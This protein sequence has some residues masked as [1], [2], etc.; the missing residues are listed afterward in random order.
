MTQDAANPKDD[1]KAAKQRLRLWLRLLGCSGRL[2]RELRTRLRRRF[3]TTLPRFD[4]L[5]TLAR[6]PE[7]MTMGDLSRRLM[8]SAGNTTTVVERLVR[9]G[10]LR[11]WSPPDD[12]RTTYVGL[13]AAG[14]QAFA[15]LARAHERW[16]A[17]L[18]ADL[19]ED[20]VQSLLGLLL[21]TR[22]AI[23]AGIRRGTKQ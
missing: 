15:L 16:I 4:V 10:Q 12:R 7:G 18:I 3:G 23:E 5:A 11:R 6:T 17:E 22:T 8:V 20:D 19:R 14:E 21:R 2:E 1:G 13:T 9:D